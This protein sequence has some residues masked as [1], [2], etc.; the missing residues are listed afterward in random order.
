MGAVITM[1]RVL[2]QASHSGL[3]AESGCR[4]GG[5][6]AFDELNQANSGEN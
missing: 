6:A 2:Y 3:L 4:S 5:R 1:H